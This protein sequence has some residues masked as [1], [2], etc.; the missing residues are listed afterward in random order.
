MGNKGAMRREQFFRM[1]KAEALE[2]LRRA[3]EMHLASTNEAGAPILRVLNFA[4][5]DGAAVF[6]GS[7]V[8]EKMEASGRPAVISVEETV[9]SVPSYFSDPE[10]ACPAT[11]LYRSVQVHG[12]VEEVR[13]PARKARALQALME[14]YQ[15]EGGHVPIT[16]DHPLYKKA[17][18]GISVMAVALERVD[19]KSKLA[20]NRKTE[21]VNRLLEQLW[22]RGDP[23]DARAVDRVRAANPAANPAFLAC[24]SGARL[25]CAPTNSDQVVTI[26]R[27]AYWNVGV[28]DEVIARAH[29]GAT[30][31]V[32]AVSYDDGDEGRLVATA[33][34]I[35][36]GSK[37]AAIFDVMVA[38]SWRGR[39]LGEAVMRLLLD[40]PRVRHARRVWLATSDA[41]SFYA[42]LGFHEERLLPRRSYPTTEMVLARET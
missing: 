31:W 5:A 24:P 34:A 13:D 17:V 7:P 42:R 4:V 37:W 21:E 16:A 26:L 2:L 8:G 35:S 40:H 11:T 1:E 30:A 3:P 19:G 27:D 9:A 6:H 41:Q 10:R 28:A 22:R 29:R 39:R 36:D 25:L 20:Q 12:L 33:R 32:A 14:K 38:E 23:G 18:E 15:P